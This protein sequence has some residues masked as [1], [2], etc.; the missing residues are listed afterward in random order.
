M[1]DLGINNK[2]SLGEWETIKNKEDPIKKEKKNVKWILNR[3]FHLGII[4]TLQYRGRTT[5]VSPKVM[6]F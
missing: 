2:T 6:Y 1:K 5:V 3:S 4:R